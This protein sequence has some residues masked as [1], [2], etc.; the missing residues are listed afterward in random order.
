MFWQPRSVSISNT[1]ALLL[2]AS[3]ATLPQMAVAA[4]DESATEPGNLVDRSYESV[5]NAVQRAVNAVDSFFVD[6]EQSTFH[7]RKTRI[8]LRLN[9]T[10]IQH[11]G[12]EFTPKVKLHLV[13]PGLGERLRL[14]MND[15]QDQGTDQASTA[16]D[17]NDVALRWIG[18]QSAKQGYSFDLGL[19]IKSGT[20]D[21]FVRM[22][23][24]LEYDLT[25]KWVGQSTNRLYYYS[26]TG[27]RNDFRQYF[28]RSLTDDFLF[29]S[30][31]RFQYFEENDKNPYIEQKFSVFQ[32]VREGLKIAYDAIY[33]QVSVEDS[34]FD[35]D[36]ILNFGN[37]RFNH[38]QI[39]LRLRQQAFRPWFFVEFWPVVLWTEERNYDTVLGGRIRLEINLGG[40]GDQRLDE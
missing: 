35:E 12:W 28:N 16:D 1:L 5:D 14:V 22:N 4:A 11:H 27:V 38:Y 30:R 8:R 2:M 13:L 26:K 40:S 7:E 23:A 24:G 31:T 21:P 3:A 36:E 39:Q 32:S 29:R 10:Y 19:R 25:G 20:P 33:R 37:D 34:P 6:S 18:K 15:D 17:D 9:N